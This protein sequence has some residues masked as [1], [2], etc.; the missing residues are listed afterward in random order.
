MRKYFKGKIAWL[1]KEEGGREIIYPEGTKYGPV[2]KWKNGSSW[3][4]F[5]ICPDF[6]KTDEVRFT[7]LVD[8]APYD[9]VMIGD[10]YDLHE[11]SKVVGRLT[12]TSEERREDLPVPSHLDEY[13]LL[14]GAKNDE[15]HAEG[16]LR[17]KCGC[18]KFKLYSSNER[19]IVQARCD[20]C[21]EI[22][23]VFDSG[24]HGWNGFVCKDDYNDRNEPMEQY[25]CEK[26]GEDVFVVEVSISSQG[27]QDFLDECVANDDS[28]SERDWRE[29]FEWISLSV[30]C[31]NCKKHVKNWLDAET[32]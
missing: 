12:V 26:C 25:I 9:E 31:W 2:I 29:A 16:L 20:S 27:K 14:N 19:Q 13:L 28:F 23:I 1:S 24:K 15:F 5:M 17:C 30:S 4:L 7:F 32:M 8:E 3:S 18:T 11:G 10:V 22:I 21:G 6:S